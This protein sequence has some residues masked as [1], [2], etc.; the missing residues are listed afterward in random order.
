MSIIHTGDFL[1][2]KA[3]DL[4]VPVFWEE[5]REKVHA[6][7]G[8]INILAGNHEQEI[9][10][11]INNGETYGLP[12]HSL[13]SLCDLIESL[14]LFYVDGPLLFIHAHPTVEFLRVL[15]HYKNVTGNHLNNFNTDHYKKAF[16]SV[17]ALN[18]YNYTRGR[19]NEHH[20][21]YDP[22]NIEA[23]YRKNGSEIAALL[24][25]LEIDSIIHGHRPQ[26]SGIQI[27]HE[28]SQWLP[29]I[30]MIG[31]DTRIRLKGIGATLVRMDVGRAAQ[32][33]FINQKTAN[34][35]T[36]KKVRHLLRHS[37]PHSAVHHQKIIESQQYRK[38]KN[39]I[40]TMSEEH[41]Y[42]QLQTES[43]LQEQRT[44]H[45]LLQEEL[46]EQDE[47]HIQTREKLKSF[48]AINH[49][50]EKELLERDEQ[51]Q[52]DEEL[53]IFEAPDLP[54]E[55]EQQQNERNLINEQ[56][57]KVLESS[58]IQLQQSLEESSHTRRQAV[59]YLRL[60]HDANRR[61]SQ[62]LKQCINDRSEAEK[63]HGL[64]LK[65]EQELKQQ[66]GWVW[67]VY[68]AIISSILTGAVI[69]YLL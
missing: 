53:P 6:S 63:T 56:A 38:L 20:L 58:N 24:T 67:K 31:N 47:L 10:Q 44:S 15:L 36:R 54:L 27:D 5:L 55:N 1:D 41:K 23:Y 52:L 64:T 60:S 43:E 69:L 18:Q 42:Q 11:K 29:E 7:G 32:V 37:A 59:D 57:L 48:E 68:V 26:R 3:P 25:K 28:F 13:D 62:E 51:Q 22:E 66:S 49:Q 30:R 33:V 2:K 35:K 40:D 4:Q 34:K 17:E 39:Q 16:K 65:S 46:R 19:P 50:L 9:W 12:K 14:D 61:M 45:L 21:L 8:F